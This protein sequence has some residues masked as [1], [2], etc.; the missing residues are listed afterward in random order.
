[1]LRRA[2]LGAAFALLAAPATAHAG[3]VTRS[4]TILRYDAAPGTGEF[5]RVTK[6]DAATIRFVSGDTLTADG[7]TGGGGQV[8]CAAAGIARVVVNLGDGNDSLNLP[9]FIAATFTVAMTVDGG[10]GVDSIHTST[11][12]D[13]VTGGSDGDFVNGHGGADAI[14]GGTGFD[15]VSFFGLAGVRASLDDVANDGQGNGVEGANVHSDVEDLSGGDGDDV[16]IG[17]AKA[18]ELDGGDGNDTLDG[19]GGLDRYTLGNGND[20]ALARD[21]LGE[22]IACGDG[23]DTV[24]GD[25]IDSLG[26]CESVALSSALVSDLDHD[27]IAKPADCNDANPAIRPGAVDTPDDGVDQD[28]DGVDA[29]NRD[30]DGDGVTR[31]LDCDDT[32]PRIAPGKRERYGNKI[33][34]DCD[35]RA[36]PL[37]SITTPVLARFIAAPGAALIVRLQVLRPQRGTR[38]QVRCRGGG[39]GFKLRKLT[40]KRRTA[41]LDLRKRFRL[42]SIGSQTLEVRLLRSD[43]I[44][45]V[46]RFSGKG[47]A[48]PRTRILCL[49]PGKKKPRRC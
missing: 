41:K 13:V 3:N 20:T 38:V 45:R 26:G 49:A 8:D 9:P 34:E 43:S 28:C 2:L 33:D 25:S 24:T 12:A 32:N 29:T 23:N 10:P 46:V 21:G 15:S 18:N 14:S 31:P 27:G 5:L 16:L 19:R 40:V 37:Q 48:I 44:G 6:P 11:Q 17:S 7:C 39:C 36:N 35:G 47:G 30:G 42:R 1:M 4:G 22:R